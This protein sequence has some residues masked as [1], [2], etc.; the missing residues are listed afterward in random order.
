M[1][2][3]HNMLFVLILRQGFPNGYGRNIG[4][5]NFEWLSMP[6]INTAKQRNNKTVIPLEAVVAAAVAAV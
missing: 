6:V 2:Q 4:G 1:T 5:N 3:P